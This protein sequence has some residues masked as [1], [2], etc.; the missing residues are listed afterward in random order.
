MRHVTAAPDAGRRAALHAEA[1][2]TDLADRVSAQIATGFRRI[3]S[4]DPAGTPDWVRAMADGQDAG[5]FGPGSAAWAVH[6]ALPTIVG[7]IRDNC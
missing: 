2:I 4:G 7:G 5:Y 6:G 1:V 3:V